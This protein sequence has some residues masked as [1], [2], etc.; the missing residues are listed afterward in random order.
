MVD[1]KG[2][3]D[4]ARAAFVISLSLTIFTLVMLR[5]DLVMLFRINQLVLL[6]V[7]GIF[8]V[9]VGVIALNFD[10]AFVTFHLIFFDNDLWILDPAKSLLINI[11]PQEFF[12][13][14]SI[15][16]GLIFCGLIAGYA[17]LLYVFKRKCR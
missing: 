17:V 9:L 2:L 1:V 5:N 3:F 12:I 16:V 13:D 7:V 15:R 10:N 11:V 4:L 6:C 14:I 8:A